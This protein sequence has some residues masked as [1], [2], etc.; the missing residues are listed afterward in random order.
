M[1]KLF[2]GN[3]GG[4]YCKLYFDVLDA[5]EILRHKELNLQS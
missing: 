3:R 1:K 5:F 2:Y 4:I